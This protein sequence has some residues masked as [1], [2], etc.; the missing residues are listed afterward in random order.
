MNTYTIIPPPDQNESTIFT[1]EHWHN[2]WSGPGSMQNIVLAEGWT[3]IGEQAFEDDHET[4]LQFIHIPAS[5]FKI[6][7]G[8]FMGA[9]NVK[10]VIFE[11]N[12]QIAEISEDAFFESGLIRVVMDEHALDTLNQNI[13]DIN[14][15]NIGSL[16]VESF[17][18]FHE[19][20][21][22][23][24][25]E[26]NTFYGHEGVNI[27]RYEVPE[28]DTTEM[29]TTEINIG[30]V[31]RGISSSGFDSSTFPRKEFP[32]VSRMPPNHGGGK[33]RTKK[34][35]RRKSRKPTM[36]RR[37]RHKNKSRRRRSRIV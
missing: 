14:S 2:A 16:D 20:P 4:E 12:S 29:D 37:R 24:F 21:E 30:N 1:N 32:L 6:S 34:R 3:E 25:G 33:V 17:H 23:H 28:M 5:V 10:E 27:V 18:T 8:A 36:R 13:S 9:R 22:L 7:D 26:N 15:E 35:I 19:I 11:N 31:L